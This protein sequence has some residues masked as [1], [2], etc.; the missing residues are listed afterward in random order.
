MVNI[1]MADENNEEH[2]KK[3]QNAWDWVAND[4]TRT[5]VDKESQDEVELFFPVLMVAVDA[6]RIRGLTTENILESV[7]QR[8]ELEIEKSEPEVEEAE[9]VEVEAE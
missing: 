2:I 7:Q 9:I 8:L 1:E 3:L 6:L 4:L 5:I